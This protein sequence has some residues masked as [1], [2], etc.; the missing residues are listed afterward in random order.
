MERART[1]QGSD[2]KHP[3]CFRHRR[4][5]LPTPSQPKVS[6]KTH[7]DIPLQSRG[8]HRGIVS[9]KTRSELNLGVAVAR[10]RP[11]GKLRVVL[12]ADRGA[13]LPL[14]IPS[15][16]INLWRNVR[17]PRG[18][19]RWRS[20]GFASL[21]Q[22]EAWLAVLACTKPWMLLLAARERATASGKQIHINRVVPEPVCCA[23]ELLPGAE[24]A[25]ELEVTLCHMTAS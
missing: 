6:L 3:S 24:E 16:G 14:P 15:W 4:V 13:R 23:E 17:L 19:G 18:H 7:P 11:K 10:A 22:R 20:N 9:R 5:K 21:S 2:N 8:F 25:P 12:G 1:P